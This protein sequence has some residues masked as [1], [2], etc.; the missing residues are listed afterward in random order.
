MCKSLADAG[1]GDFLGAADAPYNQRSVPPSNLD[2]N[3]DAPL[4]PYKYY[5]YQVLKPLEVIGGPI[6]PWFGQPG[7]GTQFYTGD[8][9]SVLDLIDMGYLARVNSSVLISTAQGCGVGDCAL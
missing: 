8:T 1:T 4:Y 2:T 3:P 5:I 9:G 6:A 7:L